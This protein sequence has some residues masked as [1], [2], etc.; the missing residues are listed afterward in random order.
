VNVVDVDVSKH[1]FAEQRDQQQ[2]NRQEGEFD[3]VNTADSD[4]EESIFDKQN[5][6]GRQQYNGLFSD[7]A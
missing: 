6:Q 7:F 4:S 1:S 3:Q 5:E 2:A